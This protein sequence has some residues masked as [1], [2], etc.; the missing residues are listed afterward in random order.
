MKQ[1]DFIL[2]LRRVKWFFQDLMFFDIDTW[3]HI[4]LKWQHKWYSILEAQAPIWSYI[5]NRNL[6]SQIDIS[7][8]RANF[9]K[10]YIVS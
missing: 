5:T 10:M 7:E 2:R 3:Y 6:F 1:Y 8:C 9:N 4:V